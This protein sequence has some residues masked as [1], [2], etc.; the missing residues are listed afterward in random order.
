MRG[1]WYGLAFT[2]R[3]TP[4]GVGI[5]LGVQKHWSAS[6]EARPRLHI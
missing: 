3:D 2:D 4:V 6:L 5:G 1:V